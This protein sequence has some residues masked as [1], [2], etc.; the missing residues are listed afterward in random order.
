M[1]QVLDFGSHENYTQKPFPSSS[2]EHQIPPL[3]SSC[4]NMQLPAVDITCV[5]MRQVGYHQFACCLLKGVKLEPPACRLRK[6]QL[7]TPHPLRAR[8]FFLSHHYVLIKTNSAKVLT[9]V[10]LFVSPST[11]AQFTLGWAQTCQR[12]R[13]AFPMTPFF[14]PAV[15]WGELHLHP[16][17]RSHKRSAHTVAA[18]QLSTGWSTKTYRKKSQPRT[19]HR[20]SHSYHPYRTLSSAVWP[21]HISSACCLEL[22]WSIFSF[23]ISLMHGKGVSCRASLQSG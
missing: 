12:D 3:P 14:S 4:S 16:P 23:S 1:T 15:A 7:C 8:Y 17:Q 5:H 18:R 13:E 11:N 10:P 21:W 6:T 2:K 19:Q 22:L 9:E 20:K